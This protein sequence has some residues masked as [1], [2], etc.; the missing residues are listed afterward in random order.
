MNEEIAKFAYRRNIQ[1]FVEIM[2]SEVTLFCS[3]GID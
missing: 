2:Y 1:F 3:L